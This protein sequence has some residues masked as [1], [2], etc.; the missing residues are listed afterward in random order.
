MLITPILV[1][2][3]ALGQL[4]QQSPPSPGSPGQ[5]PCAPPCRDGL[6]CASGRCVSPCNPPCAASETCTPEL[7]CIPTA[8]PVASSSPKPAPPPAGCNPPCGPAYLCVRG[9][10]VSACNPPCAAG[11]A[12]TAQG[13]CVASAMPVPAAGQPAVEGASDQQPGL[14][15]VTRGGIFGIGPVI[16]GGG[17]L[18]ADFNVR[19]ADRLAL[20][21]MASW[22]P[23]MLLTPSSNLRFGAGEIAAGGGLL[24]FLS[25]DRTSR[26]QHGVEARFMVGT[27]SETYM[28]AVAYHLDFYVRR[29][30]ALSAGAGGGLTIPTRPEFMAEQFPDLCGRS[31]V[32]C[33]TEPG[34]LLY[35]AFGLRFYPS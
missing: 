3:T 2:I 11:E 17:L 16:G 20:V 13:E 19:V 32:V 26:L 14:E 34:F 4:A 9:S 12:C 25:A 22:R 8:P 18:G 28:P 15:R 23:V 1:A 27:S 29:H 35:W 6:L 7:D 30:V 33:T 10:C 5:A 24:V 31:N 21:G